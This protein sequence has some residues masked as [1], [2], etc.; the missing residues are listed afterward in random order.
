VCICHNASSNLRLRSGIA[1][2]TEF[3]RR[4]IPVALG[5]DEAGLND[6]RDMLQEMRLVKHLHAVPGLYET[7]LAPAQIFRMATETGA[8]SIGFGDEIGSI[9]VGKRADLVVLDYRRMTRPYTSE[10]T[11][12][13]AAL[14]HR[15]KAEHVTATMIEGRVVYRD[16]Q[17]SFVDR[18]ATLN[19]ITRELDR[20]A[21]PDEQQRAD[22]SAR[23]MPHLTDF[24]RDW[25]I[26]DAQPWYRL[27]GR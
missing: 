16:G 9:E 15:G 25:D 14:I 4:G 26:P 10:A 17:F 11:S 20:H 5:I 19:A 23:L 7:P 1:P 12:P 6:D 8:R 24:Y 2:V 22:L 27:N 18:E 13:V 21:R 3:M